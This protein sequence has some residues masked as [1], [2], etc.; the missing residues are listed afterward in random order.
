M[1]AAGSLTVFPHLYC[2]NIKKGALALNVWINQ[3]YNKFIQAG[4]CLTQITNIQQDLHKIKYDDY[5]R[6]TM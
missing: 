6:K 4:K 5:R 3:R 2:R 1:L